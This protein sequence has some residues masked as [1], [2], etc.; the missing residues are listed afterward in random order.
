MAGSWGSSNG[1]GC[2]S[3]CRATSPSSASCF[4]RSSSRARLFAALRGAGRL[5][6]AE[7]ELEPPG[8]QNT[9]ARER[10]KI[11]AFDR[12]LASAPVS[13]WLCPLG[14]GERSR[15]RGSWRRSIHR[16]SRSSRRRSRAGRARRTGPRAVDIVLGRQDVLLRDPHGRLVKRAPTSRDLWGLGPGYYLDFPGNPLNPRLRL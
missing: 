10:F 14:L 1:A 12:C 7:G 11:P 5:E 4:A 9:T 2:R 16:C 13:S 15:Q 6:T 8:Q 3:W